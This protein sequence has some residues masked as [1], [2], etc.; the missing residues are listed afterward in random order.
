MM[1]E[2]TMDDYVTV[3]QKKTKPYRVIILHEKVN[4]SLE[5]KK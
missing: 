2:Y 3:S 1:D 4:K 5:Y